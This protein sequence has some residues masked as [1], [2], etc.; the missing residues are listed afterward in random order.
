VFRTFLPIVVVGSVDV[1]GR[2]MDYSQG[3]GDDLDSSAVG[4]VVCPSN[5]GNG[6]QHDQGTSFGMT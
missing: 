3:V 1:T 5:E 2:R 6:L 4:D